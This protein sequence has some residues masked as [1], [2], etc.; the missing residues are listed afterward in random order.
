[1]CGLTMC[2]RKNLKTQEKK[3]KTMNGLIGITPSSD[4]VKIFF[5][6]LEIW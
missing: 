4:L 6:V 5:S 2:E 3:L 1:M